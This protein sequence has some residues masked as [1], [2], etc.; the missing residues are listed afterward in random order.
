MY[1]KLE[2]WEKYQMKDIN[3][4][5]IKYYCK[6]YCEE[7]K[8]Y[9]FVDP[10]NLFSFGLGEERKK[11]VYS[12]LNKYRSLFGLRNQMN[13][14]AVGEQ[15]P[16]GFFCYMRKNHKEDSNWEKQKNAQYEKKIRDFLDQWEHLAKQVPQE[17]RNQI[18]D[19]S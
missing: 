2:K 7:R 10:D 13:H 11:E 19:A 18:E 14:A 15:N 6:E 5:L 1:S 3:H 16:I 4:Y 8:S 9:I 17:I 12:I